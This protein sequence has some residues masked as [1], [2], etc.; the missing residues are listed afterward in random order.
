MIVTEKD[1]MAQKEYYK[2]QMRAARQFKLAQRAR[3]ER[4]GDRFYAQALAWLAHR[5][6]SWMSARPERY[7]RPASPPV[8]QPQ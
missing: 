2:D 6:A 3:A 4:A 1:F 8:P 5:V 7:E